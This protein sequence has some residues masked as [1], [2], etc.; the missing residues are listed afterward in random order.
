MRKVKI[1]KTK[2]LKKHTPVGDVGFGTKKEA[3]DDMK[4]DNTLF[5]V[6]NESF[7]GAESAIGDTI[8]FTDDLYDGIDELE[9][10]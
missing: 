4:K 9:D 5:D 6:L 8:D 10:F 2:K 1:M 3:L 7:G